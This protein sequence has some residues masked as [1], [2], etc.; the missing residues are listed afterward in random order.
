MELGPLE[1]WNR[2]KP[3]QS[4]GIILPRNLKKFKKTK[5]FLRKF[6]FMKKSNIYALFIVVETDVM[7]LPS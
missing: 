3:F 5:I 4:K 1:E 6:T 2:C 7:N